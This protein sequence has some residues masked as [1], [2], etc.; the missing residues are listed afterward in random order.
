MLQPPSGAGG[1]PFPWGGTAIFRIEKIGKILKL[2]ESK[3]A[4]GRVHRPSRIGR[5]SA[6]IG[7]VHRPSRIGRGSAVFIG[8]RGL[9][10]R[11]GEN[12]KKIIFY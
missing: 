6:G 9:A 3:S 11:I 7:R 4:S 5:G 10:G 12:S 8:H 2:A 1:M